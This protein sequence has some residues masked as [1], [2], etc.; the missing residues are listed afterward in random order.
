[1]YYERNG[2]SEFDGQLVVPTGPYFRFSMIDDFVHGAGPRGVIDEYS[3]IRQGCF[4]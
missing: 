3:I 4:S 1:M 2:T